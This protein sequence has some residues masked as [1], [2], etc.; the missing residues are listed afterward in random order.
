MA[1]P[2]DVTPGAAWRVTAL[3]AALL[4]ASCA[5]TAPPPDA[6]PKPAVAGGPS[7]FGSGFMA[8]F[9]ASLGVTPPVAP[10]VA[11]GAAGLTGPS[12]A[13]RPAA[14]ASGVTPP[15]A[16]VPS[17]PPAPG[18]PP[19]FAV[20][21]KDA[22][23]IE[24]L[25]TAWQKDEKLWLELSPSDF[26]QPFFLSP[27]LTQ[28]IGEKRFL[29]GLMASPRL[30]QFRRQHNV[31]QLIALN[32]QQVAKPGSPEARAVA[33]ASSPSLLGANLVASQPHPDRKSVLVDAS[34]IFLGDLL[35][36]GVALQRTYRQG[37]SLDARNSAFVAVRGK[38]DLLVLETSNH[39]A[40][41]VIA[42]PQPGGAPGAPQPSVP[43]GVPDPRSLF[44]G[45]HYS[46]ARLPAQTMASRPADARLG[47]FVST[48]DDFS[49]DLARSPR[50]RFVNRWRLEKAD[51][52]AELSEPAKPITYWLDRNIPLKYRETITAGV[53]EWNKAFLPLGF[54]N[55][56]VV[57]QQPDDADFDTLDAGIASLRWMTNHEPSFG[58]IGPS[59]VDPRSGEIL[60]AD[61]GLESLSSR[62]L[63][64]LRA[65]ILSSAG[66]AAASQDWDELL[67]I[68]GPA[69]PTDAGFGH[70]ARACRFGDH[71]AE[72]LGYAMD[73]LA[74]R[75]EIDPDSPQA[76]QFVLDYMKDVTMHEVGHTLGLRH[77]FRASHAV[78]AA[79]VDDPEF[80]RRAAFTGSVM[81]YA[82][83]NLPRP[84][85]PVAAPF[86]TTLG[87]YDYWAIEYAY[88]PIA[89][90][91]QAAELAR[92]AAR[93]GEAS[94]AF[95][96]DEDNSLGV[97][98]EA[99]MFDLGD[100]VQA[101]ATRRFD[102][103]QDLFRRQETRRLQPG[104]DYAALRRSLSYAVRDAGR[105]AGILLRQ[106]GGVRTL[107]DLPNTGRD[108]LQPVPAAA[109]R[110]ALQL[111]SQ[112]VLA[113]DGLV[114]SPALQR[115]MAP[116]YFERD[117]SQSG[118]TEY[119][120]SQTVLDLQRSLL[121]RLMSDA[122]AA[123]VLDNE[124]KLSPP[125]KPLR[126][127][128]LYAQL[129]TDVWSELT[130]RA[131]IPQPR[132]ELQREYINRLVALVLRPGSLTRSDARA[133]VR[134][135]SAALAQRIDQAS[136]HRGLGAE[137]RAH[138]IDS[139]ESLR[140][141]LAAPLQRAGV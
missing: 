81:E 116:D 65:R 87:L 92:I 6:T 133:L 21:M 120:V 60:D 31:V 84:G 106:V 113:A 97:D 43:S 70:D 137:A 100:D 69:G 114:V 41:A 112:R 44:L 27:K 40:A 20:V 42:V 64:H 56:I 141:A 73:V 105:A 4:V 118:A 74:A 110:A 127:T 1:L 45:V 53:L 95:G 135:R 123:R 102:I 63:R 130:Q 138:L 11:N 91:G 50:Q 104:D 82:P 79:Q 121:N 57:K 125:D 15:G 66:T 136:R 124:A 23:K 115:K 90:E 3:A 76:R 47:H 75:G 131:D 26:D 111:L 10:A 78:S 36:L 77:N 46:L 16:N 94:L 35:G 88:K 12:A 17:P 96:T 48:S 132:R 14:A 139:A 62:S 85:E 67:Q 99:L 54:K 128:E 34:G 24:G 19:P 55:A 122:L 68:G 140:S 103:A 49:D 98:P 108:P 134:S 2:T 83:V 33:S 126:L 93:S 59:H 22:R 5:T 71:G 38:P 58:A 13:T 52:S 8:G 30:V 9:G 129:E 39:F 109:Q 89:A 25:F 86:Q 28:G 72:Q 7:G 80:S 37:Y 29:G 61:I 107:R 101:F 51:P 117:E 32:L 119:S 18:Q